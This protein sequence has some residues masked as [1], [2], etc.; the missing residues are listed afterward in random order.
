MIEE[1]LKETRQTS[2]LCTATLRYFNAAGADPKGEI[3]E[4]HHPETHLIPLAIKTALKRRPSFT[5]YGNNH[6]TPDGTPI[7]DFIHVSDL[8][9][10][11]VKALEYLIEKRRS[12]TLNLG[13]G[14]GYSVKEVINSVEKQLKCSLKIKLAPPFP[15]DP[16]ILIANHTQAL[17]VLNA[18]LRY[19]SLDQ[20]VATAI[21]WHQR[22]QG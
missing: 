6:K 22:Y 8:A 2:G 3:G 14:K 11:H 18:K 21:N 12:F 19:S 9:Q 17:K 4:A 7:R 1:I 16:P 5:L 15:K 13:T 10:G 20:I